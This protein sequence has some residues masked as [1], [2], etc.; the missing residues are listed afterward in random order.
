MLHS[1]SL[2]LPLCTPLRH[3]LRSTPAGSCPSRQ[4][5]EHQVYAQQ[6][7]RHDDD[8]ANERVKVS[9][10]L[11]ASQ[12]TYKKAD[13]SKGNLTL[14]YRDPPLRFHADDRP[15]PDTLAAGDVTPQAYPIPPGKTS[16]LAGQTFYS[17]RIKSRTQVQSCVLLC[18][19]YSTV[20]HHAAIPIFLLFNNYWVSVW[21]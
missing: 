16:V 7:N 19:T 11:Y 4:V 12:D 14:R 5:G 1:S 18:R 9:C 20:A 6:K 13:A 3:T 21:Q 2:W 10:D 15:A 17:S 8:E